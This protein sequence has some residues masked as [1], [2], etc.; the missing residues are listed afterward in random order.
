MGSP[1]ES[2]PALATPAM[3]PP[4]GTTLVVGLKG[5]EIKAFV[6]T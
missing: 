3:M 1:C 5:R 4:P 6:T 2:P